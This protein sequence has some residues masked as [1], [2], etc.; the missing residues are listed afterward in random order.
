MPTVNSLL[1]MQKALKT[2]SAQLNEMKNNITSRTL[3]KD[4]NEVVEPTY[5]IKVVDKRIV[6]INNAMFKIDQAVKESNA[7]TDVGIHLDF[8]ALMSEID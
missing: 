7:K 4:R 8:D 6:A 2:R 3:Y 5:D 1:C